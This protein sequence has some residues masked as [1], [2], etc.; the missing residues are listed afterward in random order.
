MSSNVLWTLQRSF[1]YLNEADR[2]SIKQDINYIKQ[3]ICKGGANLYLYSLS[4][5]IAY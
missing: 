1:W 5:Y 4:L 3:M 2:T